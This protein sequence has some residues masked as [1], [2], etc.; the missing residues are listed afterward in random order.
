MKLSIAVGILSA[1]S[2]L[3]SEKEKKI[4]PSSDRQRFSLQN[5]ALPVSAT[6]SST[7]SRGDDRVLLNRSGPRTSIDKKEDRFVGHTSSSSASRSLSHMVECIPEAIAKARTT[8]DVG[9]LEECSYDQPCVEDDQSSL[10]GYCYNYGG[11]YGIAKACDPLSAGFDAACDCSDFDVPT[12]T[13]TIS[14]PTLSDHTQNMGS[15]YYGCYGVRTIESIRTSLKDNKIISRGS[16]M[17][18]VVGDD[19]TN[20]TKLCMTLD[21]D[22]NSFAYNGSFYNGSS[23]ELQID[24][25]ACASCTYRVDFRHSCE[26]LESKADCSNVVDGLMIDNFGRIDGFMHDGFMHVGH[27]LPVIQACHK[28]INGT[29]CSLCAD[30]DDEEELFAYSM[31]PISLDGFGSDFTCGGL[32]EANRANQLSS[33]KCVEA[34]VLAKAACCKAKSA[35][36]STA[37]LSLVSA[38]GVFLTG[39]SFMFAMN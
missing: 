24:G 36:P 34:T 32:Y 11:V 17:E 16:C 4:L 14:C 21:V 10:G 35:A 31:I 30:D 1:Q 27:N 15:S 12:K 8:A 25:Q 23:C 37:S 3:A 29:F 9:V 33:D 39:T 26:I 5:A 18:L 2:T 13:G 19:V 20:S 6:A 38:A 22:V 7:N 28:P